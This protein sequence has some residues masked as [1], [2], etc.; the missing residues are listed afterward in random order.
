MGVRL[1]KVAVRVQEVSEDEKAP[2][3]ES[4]AFVSYEDN[5]LRHVYASGGIKDNRGKSRL[6]LIPPSPLFAIGHVLAYG[7]RKYRPHNAQLGL[8]WSD[9]FASMQRHLWAWLDLEDNDP[10]TGFSHLAHAACQLLFLM[11]YGIKGTGTDDRWRL[12][13]EESSQSSG[14]D[15]PEVR[16]ATPPD[17]S[18]R[19]P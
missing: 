13:T 5:P 1:P 4:G 17:L 9:T 6:D 12:P 19:T 16:G 3:D 15:L 14:R 10:E 7:A 11:E 2:Y 18:E 8:S